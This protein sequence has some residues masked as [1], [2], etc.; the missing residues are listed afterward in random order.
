MQVR[1]AACDALCE[2]ALVPAPATPA[3]PSWSKPKSPPR[4]ADLFDLFIG[5]CG[6]VRGNQCIVLLVYVYTNYAPEL[7]FG[8]TTNP[9]P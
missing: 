2:M 4:R 5:F 3:D 7:L 1:A 6:V 8:A 9:G